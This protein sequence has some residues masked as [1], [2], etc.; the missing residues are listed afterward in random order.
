MEILYSSALKQVPVAQDDLTSIMQT[1]PEKS[2]LVSLQVVDPEV[3][4]R[5]F[6]LETGAF[7]N[8]AK[9]QR[10]RGIFLLEHQ[11]PDFKIAFSAPNIKPVPIIFAVNINFT[12]YDLEPLSV[13]FIHPLSFKVLTVKELAL[14]FGRKIGVTNGKP[15]VQ[16]L[17]LGLADQTAF[18]CLPGIREYH[19]HP[20]HSNDPWFTRRGK[21]GE[22]TLGHIVD[23]LYEYGISAIKH[24]SVNVQANIVSA[25]ITFDGNKLPT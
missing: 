21:G 11:F 9:I 23:K 5:K 19:G 24:L 1:G 8:A 15:D 4:K 22:G 16:T 2:G 17:A 10:A 25:G 13:K 18:I 20:D 6:E 3:S 7:L 12:N 14:P